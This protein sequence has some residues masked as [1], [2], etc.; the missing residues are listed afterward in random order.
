MTVRRRRGLEI[1]GSDEHSVEDAAKS[2]QERLQDRPWF[3][4]VGIGESNGRLIIYIYVRRT[5]VAEL[6]ALKSGWRNFPVIIKK[7]ALPR[8]L[9][10]K[11]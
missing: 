3:N 11:V 2:L 8:L 5:N 6:E 4:L 9:S 1:R 7:S 10:R